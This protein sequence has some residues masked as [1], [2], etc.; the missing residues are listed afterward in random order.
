MTSGDKYDPNVIGCIL[1]HEQFWIDHHLFLL[2]RGYQLRPRYHPDWIPPWTLPGA[3]RA[4]DYEES[5]QETRSN[6]LDAV[7]ISD[8]SKVVLKR[9]RTWTP[10]I[11]L[12][13]H[14]NSEKCLKDPH[15]RT[16]RLLD[17]I[18]LFDDDDFAIIV[19]PFLRLFDSPVFRTFHE[20]T[21]AMLQLLQGL[22]FLHRQKVSHRDVCSMNLMMDCTN[23]IPAGFHFSAPW[24]QD[25]VGYGIQWRSRSAVSPV[26]YYIID[27]GLALFSPGGSEEASVVGVF[28][29]DRTVPELSD[30]VPYNPFK[31]DIYQLGN[32]FAGL[33]KK[34]PAMTEY[35]EPLASSMTNLNPA[36]R[37][38]AFEALAHFQ[39]IYSTIVVHT[40]AHKDPCSKKLLSQERYW[41]DHQPFLS[42]R[43][44]MLR[45]RYHPGWVASWT[46]PGAKI[47]SE[48]GRVYPPDFE[49]S[50]EEASRHNVLDAIRISDGSKVVLK[51]VRTCMPEIG[52]ALY[53][54]SPEL[55]RDPCNR[56]FRLLDVIP[57]PD[58]D[59]FAI[60]VMP[61]LQEFS[62]PKF[63]NLQEITEAMR[64]FLQGL[65]FMHSHNIAHRDACA[66]NMMMD[67]SKVIPGGCHFSAPWSENGVGAELYWRARSSVSPVDY[68]FI[69]LG[70][71]DYC[72]AGPEDTR[73]L[74]IFGQ[75]K[76]V[77]ELSDTVLYNPFKVDIYQ[78]GNVFNALIKKYPAMASHFQPLATSMTEQIPYER[79]TASQALAHF[80]LICSHL[81]STDLEGRLQLHFPPDGPLSGASDSDYELFSDSES[82]NEEGDLNVGATSRDVES[83]NLGD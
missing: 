37:P 4:V 42:S 52:I 59:S 76:T 73:D 21:E 82:S 51:R 46:L 39:S 71:S 53:L 78:L 70:L 81:T 7:R 27:F 61:F 33:N 38:T 72:P 6:V 14:L 22:E 79:P 1:S 12:G 17:I 30:S 56:T 48:L 67:A 77:P 75:D 29:Q 50:V 55:R 74:G 65:K 20:V 19:M 26:D 54:N 49:D 34:Y 3:R 11:A 2:S 9:V 60:L 45:P 57:L 44:Y 41:V 80:E 63:C 83:L 43:G 58:D 28:G 8:G 16:Y 10:E 31:V 40:P 36:E 5:Y 32:V 24:S 25:G 68:Y 15:N 64:Q 62:R 35:F 18:P 66:G 13:R 69:D 47:H 23:V